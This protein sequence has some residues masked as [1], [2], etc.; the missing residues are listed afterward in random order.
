MNNYSGNSW[1]K[2][3]VDEFRL[4]LEIY[5]KMDV[6]ELCKF[7]HEI[8][9][10]QMNIRKE[11]LGFKIDDMWNKMKGKRVNDNKGLSR[12]VYYIAQR[13]VPKL[14]AMTNYSDDECV[15]ISFNGKEYLL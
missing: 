1:L 2:L 5:P 6:Y 7:V 4:C 15:L 9:V 10:A 8:R 14:F 11:I 12:L 13:D 3:T